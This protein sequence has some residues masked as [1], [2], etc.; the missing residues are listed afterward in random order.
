MAIK[1]Y[2]E[3]RG[4]DA[5]RGGGPQPRLLLGGLMSAS[6]FEAVLRLGPRVVSREY[7]AADALDGWLRLQD[8]AVAAQGRT[9]LERLSAARPPL[10][11]LDMGR[12]RLM[13]VINV[14]P[15][16]FSD[17]G[18]RLDPEAAIADARK[19][20]AEGADII[21]I[22]GESTRPGSDPVS[23]EE[24]LARVLPVVSALAGDGIVLS[25]DTRHARVMREALSAGARILNDVSALTGDADSLSVAAQS[26]APLV[27]MHMRGEPKTMQR[28]PVYDDVALDVYDYLETRIGACLGAGIAASRIVIDPGIG[29]GKNLQHNLELLRRLALF[30]GLGCPI[31][32]GT[33]R[34]SFIGRIADAPN[35]K[36]RM[37]GSLA[38]GLAGAARGAQILRVHDVSESRQAIS[39]WQAIAGDPSADASPEALETASGG[40][41]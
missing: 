7:L 25:I 29:F 21:D 26:A 12:C 19:M 20:A 37:P 9:I 32:L 31:L 13:G 10:A 8:A 14:T 4:I 11:G 41:S 5:A 27:L 33:S 6:G 3:P 24:E 16:S 35:P 2:L 40:V 17:G 34:K 18:D 30:H 1:L 36:D 39:V 15:D 28:E 22:G 38:S 23:E